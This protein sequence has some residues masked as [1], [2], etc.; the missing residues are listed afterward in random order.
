MTKPILRKMIMIIFLIASMIAFLLWLSLMIGKQNEIIYEPVIIA[1]AN[2]SVQN[3][4]EP[5]ILW[6]DGSER[7]KG[8]YDV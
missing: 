2:I 4:L 6:M 1:S 8:F 3:R 5:N 7:K